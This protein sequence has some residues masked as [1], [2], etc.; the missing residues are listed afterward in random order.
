MSCR[1]FRS[2]RSASRP[3]CRGAA[4]AQPGWLKM[5]S[6]DIIT[7]ES[8]SST[9]RSSKLSSSRQ[10]HGRR[11]SESVSRNIRRWSS[12]GLRS[13]D[14]QHPIGTC[15]YV[16]ADAASQEEEAEH[17]SVKD[18]PRKE[19]H[20]ETHCSAKLFEPP[21]TNQKQVPIDVGRLLAVL[22][23]G[24]LSFLLPDVSEPDQ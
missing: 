19:R 2:R 3:F 24:R 5:P 4:E 17:Q 12:P 11:S 13:L 23:L 16:C 9:K 8:L 22:P 7:G 14:V 21:S 1:M 18:F 6:F 15:D 10:Q 20:P